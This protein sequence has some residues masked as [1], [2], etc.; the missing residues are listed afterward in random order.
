[1]SEPERKPERLVPLLA[2]IGALYFA[3]GFPYGVVTEIFPLFLRSQGVAL[4][5]I[6]L[7]GSL[8]GL[9]WTVKFLWAPI[10]DRLGSYRNW[11]RGCMLSIALLL[12]AIG[13]LSL[14]S[15]GT[16][17]F[18][19]TLLCIASATQD[20]AIDAL[21]ID[22]SSERTVGLIN[23]TRI[24][25]YRLAIITAGGGLALVADA[26]GWRIA[27]VCAGAIS[28]IALLPTFVIGE[29]SRSRTEEPLLAGLRGWLARPEA[30]LIIAVAMLYK[31]GDSALTL[32]VK[33]FWVDSGYEVAEIGVAT[34]VIGIGFT[35]AGAIVGGV[36]VTRLGL[37]RSLIHL[38][39]LQMASNAGYAIAAATGAARP[40][41]YTATILENFAGGLG[42]AAFLSFLMTVC[43]KRRAATEFALLTAL[44]GLSRMIASAASG[45]G[46]E[47]MGYATYFTLTL[48]LGIPG[49]VVVFLNRHR[50]QSA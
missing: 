16:F 41:M 38:G 4:G 5:E 43:E 12:A 17:W 44:Y 6:A 21:A 28:L 31:F 37:L 27:F 25:T 48:A 18:L 8:I 23:S 10:V 11:I 22:R 34:T 50:I 9:A 15:T 14:E 30:S 13:N 36:Y 33:P 3:E 35:I 40:A 29:S 45:Y 1:M 32:M 2:A 19:G 49:L 39:I 26:R 47:A 24:T 42:T 46:V 20:I 7:F